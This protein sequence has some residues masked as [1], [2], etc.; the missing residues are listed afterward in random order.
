MAGPCL[1]MTSLLAVTTCLPRSIARRISVRAGSSPPS[2]SITISIEGSSMTSLASVTIGAG[3]VTARGFS[4]CRTS[5]LRI[6]TGR[7]IR[8]SRVSLLVR[9]TRATPLPTVPRPRSP[10]PRRPLTLTSSGARRRFDAFES[11]SL[12]AR[13]R[14]GRLGG[15]TGLS[16]RDFPELAAVHVPQV[17]HRFRATARGALEVLA[18]QLIHRG[19]LVRVHQPGRLHQLVVQTRREVAGLVEDVGNAV[20]HPSAEV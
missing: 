12:G 6:S 15:D 7:P 10:T 19:Q 16:R 1:A 17:K 9:S 11:G 20:G 2:T 4:G 5:T 14:G 18:H 8:R 3:T 13:H